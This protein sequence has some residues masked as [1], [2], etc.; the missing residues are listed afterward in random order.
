M[1]TYSYKELRAGYE[2][3]SIK[4]R[5][6]IEA[7]LSHIEKTKDLN[8]YITVLADQ[9]LQR[10][11]ESQKRFDQGQARPLDGM[12]M[13]IK[14]NCCTLG[15][16]TTAGSRMLADFIPSYESTTTQR[17]LDDGA[18][19]L[20]K[21]NMD[22]FA[23]GSS[24]ETSYFGPVLNPW[25]NKNIVPGG[26][27]G[28]SA[29]SVAAGSAL[30]SIGTD[31]G[32]SVRQPASFCGITGMRPTYGR[33]SRYGIVAFASSLDQPG[34]LARDVE[35]NARILRSIAG[36]DAKDMTTLQHAV[37]DYVRACGARQDLK[38]MRFAVLREA[39]EGADA[40]VVSN[41]ETV[42]QCI[43]DCGGIVEEVS[44]PF[45]KYGVSVYLLVGS[46]EAASNLARYDG[47]RYTF[48]APD[49]K[50]AEDV[51]H[52]SRAQGFGEEVKRRIVLGTFALS[53]GKYDEYYLRVQ[54]IRRLMSQEHQKFL[55]QYDFLISPTTPSE[56]FAVD[57]NPD[58][59]F[60]YLQDVMTVMSA[61]V[62]L[63]ALSIPSGLGN[64]GLPLGLQITANFLEEEK[65]Y[66]AAGVLERAIG[67]KSWLAK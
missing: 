49:A 2:D 32:G 35:D 38:G 65:M 15:V 9:A 31:T 22:E 23:M 44:L 4:V 53:T 67:F 30:T 41:M 59:T 60:M 12:P 58:P 3:G 28:G 24:N 57:H 11:D 52:Y 36:H 61:L 1:I 7:Y 21:L 8:A 47:V 54:K 46:A 62:G 56:P 55:K 29:A 5:D 51:Y 45:L 17:L 43:R 26:S 48:R 64:G 42:L 6:V 34:P 27:S 10:A 50:T 37:P 13:G 66:E 63:P 19:F 25:G 16:R 33:C 40:S 18:I 14:D 39:L 20:G